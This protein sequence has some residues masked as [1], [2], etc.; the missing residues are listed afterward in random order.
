[1]QVTMASWLDNTLDRL[2]SIQE[3]ELNLLALPPDWFRKRTIDVA[4]NLIGTILVHQTGD[5]QLLAARIVETEAYLPNDPASHSYRGQTPRNGAMFAAGG[6]LYVY[7]IYGKHRCV[8]IVTEQEGI[9]AAVL[10][11]AAEPLVG[12]EYMITH[13]GRL[14]E[15]DKL[16]SGPANLARCF[17]FDLS[18]NYRPCY[19]DGVWILPA[20]C[21]PVQIGVSQ[22]IGISRAKGALLRYFDSLST[23]VSGHRS[24][25]H[26]VNLVR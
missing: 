3:N 25:A 20:P 2:D 1:M 10:I 6:C 19:R 5:G 4:P 21:G 26:F 12:I 16:L 24:A 13:R 18:D 22:R 15:I 23:A 14:I 8:N 17:G 11:R 9:G 7:R